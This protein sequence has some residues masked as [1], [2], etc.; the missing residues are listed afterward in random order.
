MN[1]D[2]KE[3]LKW[4]DDEEKL[5]ACLQKT[6]F[7]SEEGIY[8]FC[9]LM[10]KTGNFTTIK[11]KVVPELVTLGSWLLNKSGISAPFNFKDMIK[12]MAA[13]SNNEDLL[14]MRKEITNKEE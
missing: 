9:L 10:D 11:D 4:I 2:K 8:V 6:F 13:T 5:R 7:T 3:T 12:A 14:I 1:E